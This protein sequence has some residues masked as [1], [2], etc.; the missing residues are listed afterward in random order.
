MP[1]NKYRSWEDIKTQ[2]IIKCKI[3]TQNRNRRIWGSYGW[4]YVSQPD[5]QNL[6]LITIVQNIAEPVGYHKLKYTINNKS[7]QWQ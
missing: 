1:Y 3:T 4:K 7:N 2:N 5:N 6:F